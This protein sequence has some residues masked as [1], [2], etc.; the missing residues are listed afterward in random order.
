MKLISVTS[1][2]LYL[3]FLGL[4]L[5]LSKTEMVIHG[6]VVVMRSAG[7]RGGS[8]SGTGSVSRGGGG[9]ISHH[10][11]ID[12]FPYTPAGSYRFDG[13]DPK[14]RWKV[15]QFERDAVLLRRKSKQR[16]YSYGFRGTKL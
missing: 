7:G 14:E 6:A 10:R 15:H 9:G 11:S 12:Q 3:I 1:M 5:L 2:R 13:E 8:W 16:T 4:G